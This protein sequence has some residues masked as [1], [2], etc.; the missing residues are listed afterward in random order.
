[1]IHPNQTI[2]EGNYLR[3]VTNAANLPHDFLTACAANLSRLQDG[4]DAR[5]DR[6]RNEAPLQ[7]APARANKVAACPRCSCGAGMSYDPKCFDLACAFLEDIE[8]REDIEQIRAQ[9]AQSIQDTIEG[10]LSCL[11]PEP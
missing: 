4:R 11:D 10:Y 5:D 9:L 3:F 6:G 7:P 2:D 1:M 8:P